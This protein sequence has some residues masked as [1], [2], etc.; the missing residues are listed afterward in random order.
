[1]NKIYL[2]LT[3]ILISFSSC[4]SLKL[5]SDLKKLNKLVT[6]KGEVT[7]ETAKHSS[8]MIVFIKSSKEYLETL[9]YIHKKHEG[10]FEFI[11]E[12]GE[13]H[14]YAW[15]DENNNGEF[16]NSEAITH[17]FVKIDTNTATLTIPKLIIS[18]IADSKKI[19]EIKYIKKRL[20]DSVE[21]THN[22]DTPIKLEDSLFS[23]SNATKGLWE[24]YTFTKEVPFGL[25]L[26]KKYDPSKKLVLF[27]HGINGTPQNFKYILNTIDANKYQALLFYYPSG[28]RLNDIANYL[29]DLMREF[30]VKHQTKQISIIAH[31]MGGLVSKKYINIQQENNRLI[32]NNFISIST[33]WSGHSGAEL[34]LKYAPDIIPVWNDMS[35]KSNFIQTLFYPKYTKAPKHSLLFGYKGSS[36]LVS[37]NSDGVVTID[38]QLRA[39]TQDQTEIVKGFNEDHM[40]ILKNKKLVEFINNT[41]K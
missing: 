26:L 40:S 29:D 14:L 5:N 8:I 7:L 13:Y 30:Q 32:V 25:F 27:V 37:E 11:V 22:V 9:E 2:L 34:G 10:T 31:S 6:I 23:E 41:I 39:V 24:P 15:A 3:I 20:I 35:P 21:V 17:R 38:S 16:E 33:P 4:S 36:L 1:M 18:Q 19:N 28:F 12:P